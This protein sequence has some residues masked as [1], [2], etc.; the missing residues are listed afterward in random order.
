MMA[1]AVVLVAGFY[2]A[3]EVLVPLAISLLLAFLLSPL[4]TRIHKLG[5]P[6]T[7]AVIVAMIVALA[8][9]G[10]L[11][12]VLVGQVRDIASKLP[13]YESNLQEKFRSIRSHYDEA[14]KTVTDIAE[15]GLETRTDGDDAPAPQ[16]VRISDSTPLLK[17]VAEPL[18][19]VL[20]ALGAIGIV[21]LFVVLMLLQQD[22]MRDRLIRLAGNK[23]YTTTRAFD[24][25]SAKVSRYLLLTT[26]INGGHGVCIG[27][28]LSLLGI[29]NALLWGV[30]SALLRFIPYIGPW[31]AAAFPI[32]L[33]L[34][35]FPGWTTPLLTMG[36]ILVLELISNNVVEPWVYG[37]GTG[38]SPGAL[39]VATVFW[40]WLWGVPGL[41]LATPLTVCLAVMGKHVPPLGFFHVLLGD[42]P[43]LP[44]SAKLYQRLLAM[45][46]EE[47]TALL[48]AQLREKSLV[49]VY[50]ETLIPAVVLAER[51]QHQGTLDDQT[52]TFVL[53]AMRE[54]AEE[55]DDW[56]PPAKESE[57]KP[58]V[59]AEATAEEVAV[60]SVR[61]QAAVK[62]L[63]I[64]ADDESDHAVAVMAAQV[65]RRVGFDTEVVALATLTG[66]LSE[67]I[68]KKR[69]QLVLIS[70]VPPSGFTHVR[71]ICKRI[72]ANSPEIPIVIGVWGANLDAKKAAERLPEVKTLRLARS[73]KEAVD[74]A[75]ELFQELQ[76]KAAPA[77]PA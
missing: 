24:E 59:G 27:I 39:L 7:L 64:A 23:L 68:S 19:L 16:P 61:Q 63:C 31:M 41:F 52:R 1:C 35:V 45:D 8:I 76:I 13:Q 10:A 69:I 28:G 5:L 21:L 30:L 40:T 9:A 53:R 20:S 26:I 44:P 72:V 65:L 51:D 36:L 50:D 71:Y 75:R 46:Q 32:A 15:K 58:H 54:I 49:E 77:E 11:I 56:R 73:L 6:R 18:A 60:P 25:A 34:A 37:S 4:V 17:R 62:A 74:G 33:S 2:F 57:K 55:A 70:D 22:D 42:Q 43:V 38:V 66:E 3:R 14:T 47:A 29:P 67:V 12:W 48:L